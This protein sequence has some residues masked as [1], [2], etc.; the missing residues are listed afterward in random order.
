[1]PASKIVRM[2]GRESNRHG[3]GALV[4]SMKLEFRG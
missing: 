2:R 3:V 4:D 1:M